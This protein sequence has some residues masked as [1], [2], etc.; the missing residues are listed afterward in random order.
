MSTL[1]CICPVL[2]DAVDCIAHNAA[3]LN[4]GRCSKEILDPINLRPCIFA[5][6][7]QHVRIRL[8]LRLAIGFHRKWNIIEQDM[9]T[10]S[11]KVK[12]HHI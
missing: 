7:V 8:H 1:L 11:K 3:S 9:P 6:A 12:P 5:V 2:V 10:A 4:C